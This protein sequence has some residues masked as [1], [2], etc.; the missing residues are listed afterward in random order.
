MARTKTNVEETS[1]E[2][3]E[4]D[5]EIDTTETNEPNG[6]F[7]PLSKEPEEEVEQKPKE[8]NKNTELV[9]CLRNEVVIVRPI[10]R[11]KNGITNPKH[12]LY[13]GMS[14]NAKRIFSVPKLS[15]NAY[16]NVLTNSEKAFLEDVMGLEYNALSIHR[17]NNNFWDDSNEA[18]I[19]KVEL[20]KE[21]NRLNLA[22]PAD[23]IRYKILLANKN[24]I[25]P[26]LKEWQDNPKATYQF[27][28]INEGDET[29]SAKLKMNAIQL[30]YKEFGKIEDDTDTLR[31]IIEII[32]GKATEPSTKLDWLQTKANELIQADPK[33][34]ASTITDETLSTKVLIKKA[35]DTG[36]ISYRGNQLYLTSTG[37][38]L[39][40][41]NEEPTLS[42]AAKYLN[43][44]KHQNVLFVLQA[45]LK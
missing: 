38:P 42:V 40:E 31:T 14:N 13:G 16:V 37:T 8:H 36:L 39:C 29:K 41:N 7:V 17:K 1:K 2:V 33:L 35:H 24:Y 28:I 25:C 43:N 32:T 19:S 26:S 5:F 3:T 30:C 34:F 45:K 15:S 18:G 20:Y 12:V 23:Y 10:L 44:P 4:V 22:D 11:Q 9:N 6:T 27:V 21:D